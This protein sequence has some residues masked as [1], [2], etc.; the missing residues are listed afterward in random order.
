MD[1]DGLH[2]FCLASKLNADDCPI[3]KE[4]LHVDKQTQ[5]QWF[6]AMDKELQDLFKSGTFEL[7]SRDKALK[8]GEEIVPTTWAFWKKRHPSGEVY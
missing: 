8:Q 6:D 4:I 1:P 2:P 7:V 3:F 5:N